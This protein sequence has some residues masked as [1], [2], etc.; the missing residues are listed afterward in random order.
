MGTAY[1]EQPDRAEDAP[2]TRVGISITEQ[3]MA[4][5]AT[6]HRARRL[7]NEGGWVVSWLPGRVLDRQQAI[8][9]MVLAVTVATET[10][11][12][13][14]RMWP[15]IDSWAAEL[16][17]AGPEAVVRASEPVES[18]PARVEEPAA[19]GGQPRVSADPGPVPLVVEPETAGNVTTLRV[20]PRAQLR[21]TGD[22]GRTGL[23][24]LT[25]ETA[26]GDSVTVALSP[27]VVEALCQ[28]LA[29]ACPVVPSLPA[30]GQAALGAGGEA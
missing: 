26:A 8:T 5:E 3:E 23:V 25:V 7:V 12:G 27:A 22:V 15:V 11:E 9:A 21:V 18:Q 30:G 10:L 13:G 28:A 4:S 14:H 2:G 29:A 16:G 24:G 6:G 1:D 19:G 20:S 17:L